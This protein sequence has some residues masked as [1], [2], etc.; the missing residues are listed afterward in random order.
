MLTWHRIALVTLDGFLAVSAV[1]GGLALLMGSIQ[2]PL[3]WLAGSPF[4]NYI[5]PGLALLILV[6]GGALVATAALLWRPALGVMLSALAGLVVLVFLVV[7][8]LVVGSEPGLMR[9]LQMT[10]FAIGLLIVA[11][12]AWSWSSR[13]KGEPL[14]RAPARPA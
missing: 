10:Y 3:A 5:I 2:F 7:E 11:V 6:G 9:S 14:G 1:G 8:V 4:G 13:H 12:A